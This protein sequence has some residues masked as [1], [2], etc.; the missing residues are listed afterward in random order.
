MAT[1]AQK[2]NIISQGRQLATT[3]IN[4]VGQVAVFLN[5]FDAGGF[6]SLTDADFI[7]SNAGITAADFEEWIAALVQ[8]KN[9]WIGGQ[10]SAAQKV[11]L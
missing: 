4:S 7:G 5:S 8:I 6:S 9:A 2:S 3:G 11:A 10:D 1:E